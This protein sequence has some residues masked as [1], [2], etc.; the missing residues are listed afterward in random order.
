MSSRHDV[1]TRRVWL[2]ALCGAVLAGCASAPPPVTKEAKISTLKKVGFT[3]AGDGW[4]IS[5]GVKLLF[6]TDVDTL[7]VEGRTA[8]SD[9]SHTLRDLGIERIRVD[10]HTDNVG[11][12]RYNAG[13]SLRRAESVAQY[14]RGIGWR[15]DAIQRRGFGADKPVADNSTPAGRAQ[16]RRV[17]IAVQ[18]Q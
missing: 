17:V 15:D 12:D 11:S 5:L 3:P 14:L 18:V 8:V 10:G 6:D 9:L 2:A 4:E 7:S 16:N 13:L 1:A